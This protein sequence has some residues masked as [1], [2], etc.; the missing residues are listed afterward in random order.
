[1]SVLFLGDPPRN[2][3]DHFQKDRYKIP[4]DSV[5]LVSETI[6]KIT[7]TILRPKTPKFLISHSVNSHYSVLV[8][9][10]MIDSNVLKKGIFEAKNTAAFCEGWWL[11]RGKYP[12]K[13]VCWHYDVRK[14]L[15]FTENYGFSLFK[16]RIGWNWFV[17][18]SNRVFLKL[19]DFYW[20]SVIFMTWT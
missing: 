12:Y 11:L 15:N 4:W 16:K 18:I 20:F 14:S 2:S 13:Q 10:W 9:D 8:L 5:F 6:R 7:W 19:T 3:Y 1:M 17:V